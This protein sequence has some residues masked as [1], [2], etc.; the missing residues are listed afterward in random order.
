MCPLEHWVLHDLRR[1]FATHLG[2]AQIEPHIIERL[3]NHKTGSMSPIALVYNRYAYLEQMRDA[4][5]LWERTVT[6]T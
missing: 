4:M 1:S 6:G 3:L 2:E 5:E